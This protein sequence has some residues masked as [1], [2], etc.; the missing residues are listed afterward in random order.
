MHEK[1]SKEAVEVH[2][3]EGSSSE[4]RRLAIRKLEEVLSYRRFEDSCGRLQLGVY[5]EQQPRTGDLGLD[6][7]ALA[8]LME[9]L[10]GSEMC[11]PQEA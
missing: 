11:Q 1:L 4:E 9:S 2:L 10:S 7:K 8:A 5:Y 6:A 3:R